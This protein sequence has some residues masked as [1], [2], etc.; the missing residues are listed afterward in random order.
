[1]KKIKLSITKRSKEIKALFKNKYFLIGLIALV[2]GI[3]FNQISSMYLEN[4][5]GEALPVLNDLFLD[6]LP[7]FNIVWLYDLLAIFP[8]LILIIYVYKKEPKKIPY[9][10]ILFAISQLIRGFFIILTPFGSPNSGLV[11]LFPGSA[12]RAGV[13]PSGHTGTSFLAFLLTKGIWEK[14][15]LALSI[16]IM[17]TLI[18]GRGHY[19]LDIFS[20]VIFAYAIYSFGEKYLKKKFRLS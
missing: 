4:K 7:F 14:I 17:I 11:G 5:Y 13:Y 12:F 20:A 19:S 15:L 18:L 1:M 8:I 2:I 16:A 3:I 10:L 6:N 9:F